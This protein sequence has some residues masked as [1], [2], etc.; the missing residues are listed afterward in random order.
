MTERCLTQRDRARFFEVSISSTCLDCYEVERRLGVA[1]REM[2]SVLGQ[3]ETE[4]RAAGQDHRWRALAGACGRLAG[5]L[6]ELKGLENGGLGGP[7]PAAPDER[8]LLYGRE[9]AE[10]C[11]CRL[12]ALAAVRREIWRAAVVEEGW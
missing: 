5:V 1:V 9:S 11:A 3:F 12:L 4:A 8:V 7:Q 10:R 6:A 2:Q